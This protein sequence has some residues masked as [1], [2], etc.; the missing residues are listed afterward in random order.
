MFS[1][2]STNYEMKLAFERFINDIIAEKNR[3]AGNMNEDNREWI[4][5]HE[6]NLSIQIYKSYLK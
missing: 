5:N 6:H 4:G 2:L 3:K 1:E